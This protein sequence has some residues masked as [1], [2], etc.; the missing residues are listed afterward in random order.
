MHRPLI[1]LFV[2]VVAMSVGEASPTPSL[3][4]QLDSP[5][6]GT[7]PDRLTTYTLTRDNK[8]FT[9]A[10]ETKLVDGSAWKTDRPSEITGLVRAGKASSLE[11]VGPDNQLL[12][13]CHEV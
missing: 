13:T 5:I 9:L 10:I 3:F 4:R 12:Y 1:G 7:D 2:L 8:S 6:E 11:I